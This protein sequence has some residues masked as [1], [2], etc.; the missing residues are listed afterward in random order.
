M[1]ASESGVAAQDAGDS[2]MVGVAEEVEVVEKGVEV[3]DVATL[4][5]AGVWWAGFAVRLVEFAGE[6]A[7]KLCH[8]KVDFA[9]ADADGGV[10][11]D[12]LTGGACHDVTAP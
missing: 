11:E 5:I 2:E 6:A 1:L 4:G 7:E 12:G 10:D 3:V 8:G 9:V